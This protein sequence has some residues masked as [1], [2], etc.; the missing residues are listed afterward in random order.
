MSVI[1]GLELGFG[2]G[3]YQCFVWEESFSLP[4]LVL[5]VSRGN[6]ALKC[7]NGT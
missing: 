4:G 6:M 7:K 3:R 5:C 1:P 2:S